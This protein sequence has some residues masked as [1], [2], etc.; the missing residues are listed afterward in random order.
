MKPTIRT[1]MIAGLFLIVVTSNVFAAAALVRCR[2]D[3]QMWING[4]GDGFGGLGVLGFELASQMFLPEFF[5]GL[6]FRGQL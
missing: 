6:L 1:K 4:G 3:Q 2:V 5:H